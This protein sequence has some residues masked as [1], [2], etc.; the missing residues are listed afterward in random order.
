MLS[1]CLRSHAW[2][3]PSRLCNGSSS[4]ADPIQPVVVHTSRDSSRASA[5]PAA[6]QPSLQVPVAGAAAASPASPVVASTATAATSRSPPPQPQPPRT[7]PDTRTT[8]TDKKSD[9]SNGK[10]CKPKLRRNVSFT[11]KEPV[12]IQSQGDAEPMKQPRRKK[13]KKQRGERRKSQPLGEELFEQVRTK[14]QIVERERASQEQ[15]QQQF[16]QQKPRTTSS[17]FGESSS[18]SSAS[19]KGET[20]SECSPQQRPRANRNSGVFSAAAA[21]AVA[22][23]PFGGGGQSG[24]SDVAGAVVRMRPSTSSDSKSSSKR[25]SLD[26]K[27]VAGLAQ[28]L[29]AECAKAYALMESS[30]SKLSTEFGMGGGKARKIECANVVWP[31]Y[32]LKVE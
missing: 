2:F 18:S 14:L 10:V 6:T 1:L 5:V 32:V 26:T 25:S 30:L 11:E 9:A 20:S 24:G 23:A 19:S 29:A 27:T 31:A 17:A 4:A 12:I 8:D 3:S 28:D 21:A 16:Q 22:A 7:Q 13:E 15:Q